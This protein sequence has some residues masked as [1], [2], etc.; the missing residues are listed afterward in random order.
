MTLHRIDWMV[1]LIGGSS[2]VTLLRGGRNTGCQQFLERPEMIR[3]PQSH[4][5]RLLSISTH[6]LLTREP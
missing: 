6:S 3:Q 2:V 1:L 5:R 4:G